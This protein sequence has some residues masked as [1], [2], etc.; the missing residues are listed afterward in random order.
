MIPSELYCGAH[1]AREIFSGGTRHRFRI[2]A[3]VVERLNGIGPFRIPRHQ[4]GHRLPLG[5]GHDVRLKH[6]HRGRC[7]GERGIANLLVVEQAGDFENT[8]HLP[9]HVVFRHRSHREG[10]VADAALQRSRQLVEEILALLDGGTSTGRLEFR[11]ETG[12]GERRGAAIEHLHDTRGPVTF[13]LG[14]LLGR[15]ERVEH[16]FRGREGGQLRQSRRFHHLGLAVADDR[17]RRVVG[18]VLAAGK[19]QRFACLQHRRILRPLGFV[20]D[21][22]GQVG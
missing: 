7:G 20:N 6:V 4:I 9:G 21:T 8:R 12:G 16:D 2:P 1:Q 15:I 17:A 22:R 18:A 11:R 10:V 5:I 19:R 14:L 3:G 13:Q